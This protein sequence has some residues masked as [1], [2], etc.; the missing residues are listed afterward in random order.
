VQAYAIGEDIFLPPNTTT[1]QSASRIFR[2]ALLHPEAA[3]EKVISEGWNSDYVEHAIKTCLGNVNSSPE[4]VVP[5]NEGRWADDRVGLNGMELGR[6][7]LE[8]IYG[9]ERLSDDDGVPGIYCTVFCPG[10]HMDS[11]SADEIGYAKHE[12]LG[13]RHGLYPFVDFPLEKLSRMLLDTRGMPQVL[14]GNQDA[15]KVELDSRIDHASISTCPPLTHPV[16]REPGRIGPGAMVSERRPGEIGRLPTPPFPEASVEVQNSIES[17]TRRYAGRPT[18]DDTTNEWQIKQQ[19]ESQVWLGRWQLAYRMIFQLYV[20][21]G[22]EE[23]FFR[24]IGQQTEKPVRFAKQDFDGT[25]DLYL[26][27]DIL[28]NDPETWQAK[29][30]SL[31]EV[32]QAFDR[33][34]QGDYSKILQRAVEA[35]DSSWAEEFVTPKEIAAQKEVTETQGDISRMS[36]GVDL[37]AP[38]TGVN[39]QL[40]LE[41]IK[42]WMM[43]PPDNPALDVQRR[44]A[45]DEPLRNRIERYAEQLSFQIQQNQENPIIGRIGTKPAGSTGG[46]L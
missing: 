19:K 46:Q 3:R 44:L 31:A 37:D 35:I 10:C 34:G 2:K 11:N 17:R 8:F 21:Y 24:V 5:G 28:N 40:R 18:A 9:Y 38:T 22:P 41:T 14:R 15:I 26:Q 32:M 6:G 43:G 12:L 25:W 39:P 29:L 30:K 27:F 33:N 36:A 13:Y 45:S 7:L 4:F 20:Q 1:L 16:G 23:E 42:N